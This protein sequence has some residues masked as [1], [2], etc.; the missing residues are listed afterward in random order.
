MPHATSHKKRVQWKNKSTKNT[1]T[2]EERQLLEFIAANVQRVAKN[3]KPKSI[4]KPT[5]TIKKQPA[6]NPKSLTQKIAER[7]AARGMSG[8]RYVTSSKKIK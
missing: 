6:Q 4:L 8:A 1:L 3:T 5:A 7:A 2:N